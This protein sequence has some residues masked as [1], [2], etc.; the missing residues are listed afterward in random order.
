MVKVRHMSDFLLMIFACLCPLVLFNVVISAIL[1]V[2]LLNF[3]SF[4]KSKRIKSVAA[5][6]FT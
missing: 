3:F 5:M 1:F 4:C 6:M 2:C